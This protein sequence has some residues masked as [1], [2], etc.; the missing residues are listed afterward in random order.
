MMRSG[1]L[2]LAAAPMAVAAPLVA[3]AL[4]LASPG[5][6]APATGPSGPAPGGDPDARLS[7]SDLSAG[8]AH[9]PLL[10]QVER[11]GQVSYLLGTIHIG[12][13]LHELPAV[14][15]ATLDDGDTLV[16]AADV[17]DDAG[18]QL[19]GAM[20]PDGQS[21]RTMLGPDYWA[22]LVEHLGDSVPEIV[23]DRMQPWFPSIL[24]S[25]TDLQ[26]TG[27]GLDNQLIAR[28]RTGGKELVFLERG[29][30]QLAMLSRLIDIDDLKE[31]LDDVPRSHHQLRAML[32]AYRTGNL[33]AVH[34]LTIERDK[35]AAEPEYY[36]GL[37][38]ARN[39]AWMKTLVPLLSRGR[40]FVAVGA[41]HF[42][43]DDGLLVLL[44][45]EGFT[46][47]RMNAQTAAAATPRS[48]Q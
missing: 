6:A 13:D 36:D 48:T 34:G 47:R 27:D 42:V 20:L 43:G 8:P 18:E 19:A 39:R 30:E 45:R 9:A 29:T 23:L 31:V 4:A 41:G 44:R 32:R 22:I 26:Y 17:A 28:A 24:I 33:A 46:V 7:R 38:F 16:A 14:V 3:I 25:L 35:L 15:T 37:L 40:V 2:R 10:W 1:S 21:L 12:V 11:A 5:C